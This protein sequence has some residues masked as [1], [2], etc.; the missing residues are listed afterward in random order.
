[1]N[2]QKSL[3]DVVCNA[4]PQGIDIIAKE[5]RIGT[6]VFCDGIAKPGV[7]IDDSANK[8]DFDYSQPRTSPS[9]LAAGSVL[10]NAI[11]GPV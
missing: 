4:S 5:Q 6:L 7:N 9:C 1:M 10:S 2:G 8:A 11:M 3:P